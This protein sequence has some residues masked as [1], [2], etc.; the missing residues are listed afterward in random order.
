MNLPLRRTLKVQEQLSDQPVLRVAAKMLFPF[1]I[2][3]AVYVVTHGEL[4]PGG[5]FQGG[6]LLAAAFILYG[7]V[8]GVEA[9]TE[10]VPTVVTDTLMAVGCLLYAGTGLHNLLAGG[11]FLDYSMLNPEDA[12]GGEVLGMTLVEYG[13]GITVAS[14]MITV[15]VQ[16]TERAFI[17]RHEIVSSA[18]EGFISMGSEYS[19]VENSA[20]E[21][22]AAERNAAKLSEPKSTPPSA[23]SSPATADFEHDA[24]RDGDDPT[25]HST[26]PDA[27]GASA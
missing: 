14:V 27:Q 2:V 4:G 24:A 22:S 9:L 23:P 19:A 10:K 7:L 3:F 5:G 25:A 12:S 16:V 15:Y 1:I 11:N 6:V 8:F 20:A 21:N 18:A 13:V 17:S 26:H